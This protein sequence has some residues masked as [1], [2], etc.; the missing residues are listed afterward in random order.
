M[1]FDRSY[2]ISYQSSIITMTLCCTCFHLPKMKEVTWPRTHHFWGSSLKHCPAWPRETRP[3]SLKMRPGPARLR[4]P[5]RAEPGRIWSSV[6]YVT[7]QTGQFTRGARPMLVF[8]V[9]E[10]EPA[11]VRR[12]PQLLP[13]LD[14]IRKTVKKLITTFPNCSM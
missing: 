12:C 6:T 14:S 13:S 1:L 7:G 5:R 9:P 2:V 4:W 11:I 3:D 10:L 8:C